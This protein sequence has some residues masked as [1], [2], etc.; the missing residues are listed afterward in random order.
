MNASAVA[1]DAQFMLQQLSLPITPTDSVKA[2]MLRATRRAGL[3][4][5]KA[6]RIWYQHACTIAAHEYLQIKE[7]YKAHIENQEARLAKELE[8]L[9]ELQ[10]REQQHE[11]GL[12]DETTHFDAVAKVQDALV[13]PHS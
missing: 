13:N 11:L 7:A 10:A 4:P 6:V 2:R 1:A 3:S 5:R 8:H 9:R 12:A